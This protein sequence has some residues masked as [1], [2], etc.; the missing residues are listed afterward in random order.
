MLV[1]YCSCAYFDTLYSVYY[2]LL[3]DGMTQLLTPRIHNNTL[4]KK[5]NATNLNTDAML[6]FRRLDHYY[7]NN[8]AGVLVVVICNR[9]VDL[10]LR[11][12]L[13]HVMSATYII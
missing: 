8:E 12:A 2:L 11:V 1:T 7:E 13:R 3:N 4:L 10:P 5:L 9:F 6:G